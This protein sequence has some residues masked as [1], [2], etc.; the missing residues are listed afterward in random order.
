MSVYVHVYLSVSSVACTQNRID[1]LSQNYHPE[2][3][4][5]FHCHQTI[6]GTGFHIENNEFYCQKGNN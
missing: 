5:C 1:A 4:V 6:G 2:C 3:F